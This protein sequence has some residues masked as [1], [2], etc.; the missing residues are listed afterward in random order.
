MKI[1]PELKLN[2]I[3]AIEK[4]V[5]SRVYGDISE[6]HK[7]NQKPD[8]FTGFV[9]TYNRKNEE[10]EDFPQEK[11]K[12]QLKAAES[13]T[14]L[15]EK[16]TELLDITAS[17]DYANCHAAANVEVNGK[18]LVENAPTTYILFLE[19]Q[20]N[21]IRTFIEAL[22]VLDESEDWLKDDNSGL[23]KTVATPT[24]KTK[25]T[26]KAIVLYE[27]TKEHP[28]QTQLITEDITVGYWDTVK[29]SGAIPAPR[30]KQILERIEEF[31]KAVKVAREKANNTEAIKQ[32]VGKE[33][34]DYLFE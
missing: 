4:G 14:R 5:K 12:V 29:H 33:I 19:K 34:F 10:Y 3:I 24:H 16:L 23:Y 8:L 9:K 2:Q 21:D 6:L 17:K 22:P 20:I 26:Q 15:A 11:K 28:A 31:S 25:K 32:S 18:T 7:M 13:I 30:K 27:A 1:M